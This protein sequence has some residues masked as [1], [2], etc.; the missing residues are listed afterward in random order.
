MA[1]KLAFFSNN[2]RCIRLLQSLYSPACPACGSNSLIRN[3]RVC[4]R[5]STNKNE[6]NSW[7]YR[8]FNLLCSNLLRVWPAAPFPLPLRPYTATYFTFYSLLI[9]KFLYICNGRISFSCAFVL[10]HFWPLLKILPAPVD[11]RPTK[12][13]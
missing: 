8:Q 5:V 1:I 2:K 3:C 7:I 9:N 12:L 13:S 4:F 6:R 10:F 11:G